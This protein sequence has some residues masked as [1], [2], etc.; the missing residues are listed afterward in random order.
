[1]S[2]GPPTFTKSPIGLSIFPKPVPPSWFCIRWLYCSLP[3]PEPWASPWTLPSPIALQLHNPSIQ[4]PLSPTPYSFP[5]ALPWSSLVL[6]HL[7][8]CLGFPQAPSF[9]LPLW[10]MLFMTARKSFLKPIHDPVPPLH[11]LLHGSPVL[12]GQSLSSSAWRSW[13][14][15]TPPAL[16]LPQY[17]Q[18]LAFTKSLLVLGPLPGTAF[19]L[20]F[21]QLSPSDVVLRSHLS[22]RKTP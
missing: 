10:S 15:L 7:G 5:P 8:P 12:L 17:P 14:L 4:L 16:P 13:T 3:W 2:S 22:S 11:R 21:A 1:M 6:T 9:S 18:C 20:F 19:P